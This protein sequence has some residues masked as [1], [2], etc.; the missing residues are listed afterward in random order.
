MGIGPGNKAWLVNLLYSRNISW[1]KIS[2]K[3]A[4]IQQCDKGY[5]IHCVIINMQEKIHG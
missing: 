1:E 5:H 2:P 3:L 4:L